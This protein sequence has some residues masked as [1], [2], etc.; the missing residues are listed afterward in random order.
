MTDC[1]LKD[2]QSGVARFWEISD[3]LLLD[4]DND[5]DT[6]GEWKKPDY[7]LSPGFEA[8]KAHKSIDPLVV[9]WWALSAKSAGVSKRTNAH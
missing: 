5:A 1:N 6:K 3:E 8:L 7:N 2:G 4:P 9:T